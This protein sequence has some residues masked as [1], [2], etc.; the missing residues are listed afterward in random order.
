M[1]FTAPLSLGL[2]R[3]RCVPTGSCS[4][5]ADV[6]DFVLQIAPALLLSLGL[7]Q[8]MQACSVVRSPFFQCLSRG[9][10]GRA[11]ELGHS[12]RWAARGGGVLGWAGQAS[13]ACLTVGGGQ[14]LVKAEGR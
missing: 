2:G 8:D 7:M 12:G 13:S 10:A 11:G 5:A 14:C 9:S 4:Q 1:L 3:P 6:A